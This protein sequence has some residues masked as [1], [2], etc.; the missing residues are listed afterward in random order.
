MLGF[1]TS[2]C[3]QLLCSSYSEMVSLWD[4]YKHHVG[5]GEKQ[6]TLNLKTEGSPFYETGLNQPHVLL[7][8]H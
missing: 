8:V 4:L 5:G 1:Q 6:K 2:F 3:F 7:I